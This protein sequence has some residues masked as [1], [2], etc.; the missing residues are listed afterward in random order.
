MPFLRKGEYIGDVMTKDA[1]QQSLTDM[2]V[3]RSV[4]LNIDRPDPI[5]VTP[6]V[7]VDGLTVYDELGVKRLSDVSF[8]AICG[9]GAGH[10]GH[11]RQRPARAAGSHSRPL[12]HILRRSV[13][14]SRP[15]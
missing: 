4:T 13:T 3:G 8:T 6:R 1:D 7:V 14:Y 5:N 15:G 10:C 12:P 11:S 9:R 2:M